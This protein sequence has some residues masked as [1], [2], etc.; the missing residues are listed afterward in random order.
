ME[1]KTY[2]SS[3]IDN[4][5]ELNTNEYLGTFRWNKSLSFPKLKLPDNVLDYSKLDKWGEY[6]ENRI[7]FEI[8][9]YIVDA[10]SYPLS[11]IYAIETYQKNNINLNII[12]EKVIN[13]ILIG[14]AQKTEGRI[15][16]ESNYFD[17]IYYYLASKNSNLKELNLYFVGEEI[18]SNSQY[19]SKLNSNIKYFFYGRNTGEFLKE[20][21]FD[22]SKQTTL[23]FGF[24]CGF[25]AGY[26]KLSLSWVRDLI[27]LFR[28]GYVCIFSYTNDYEDKKGEVAIIKRIGGIVNCYIEDNP[29]KAMTTYKSEEDLWSCGN[30][31]LYF[32]NSFDKNKLADAIKLDDAGLI[33]LIKSEIVI[34][35]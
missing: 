12:K 25:G 22:L 32:I 4:E 35:K 5:E 27:K 14:T 9:P 11:V 31:G 19:T 24:N 3:L 18:K 7:D 23:F 17:E 10:L 34:K 13:I 30:Y 1:A 8:E 6:L 15:A 21:A 28:F 29:F 2:E 26:I 16:L 33:E 20:K